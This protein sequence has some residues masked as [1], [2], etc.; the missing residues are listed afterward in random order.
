MQHVE[1]IFEDF[2]GDLIKPD[3]TIIFDN[4]SELSNVEVKIAEFR[5]FLTTLLAEPQY[6]I[7]KF[8]N[9]RILRSG[10]LEERVKILVVYA[11]TTLKLIQAGFIRCRGLVTNAPNILKLTRSLPGLDTIIFD[12]WLEIQTCLNVGAYLSAVILMGSVLE[13]LLLS[14]AMLDAD[15][16]YRT[17]RSNRQNKPLKEWSLSELISAAIELDWVKIDPVKISFP[18][19]KYRLLIHPLGEVSANIDLNAETCHANWKIVNKAVEN[20]LKSI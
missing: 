3:G 7:E 10:G 19:R 16:V 1:K 14:R 4:F 17:K 20:L 5:I 15:K 2:L 9:D 11:K 18:L 12:R 13:A 6:L 8:D